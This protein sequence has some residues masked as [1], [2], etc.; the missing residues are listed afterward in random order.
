MIQTVII[1]FSATGNSK[2]VAERIADAIEDSAVSI[3]NADPEI[4]LKPD[5]CLG[6]V[7]PVY[8]GGLPQPMRDYLERLRL[9]GNA[10]YCFS[11][12][13]YGYTS[14]FSA[15]EVKK[16]ISKKG[17]WM[18]AAFGIQMPDTWTPVFDLSDPAAVSKTNKAAEERIKNIIDSI[19][20]RENG[21]HSMGRYPYL[22]RF[23]AKPLYDKA[24][25]TKKFFCEDTCIGCGLCARKCPVH[26]IEII[27][28]KPVWKKDKCALCLRCLHYCPQF[29]I[30]YGN[31]KTKKHG[32]YHNPNVKV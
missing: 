16:L 30:Q 21:I 24:R 32:Q 2:Y 1:Y 14:G 28:N 6:I 17:L 4:T 31:G 5:E 19:K 3:E 22:A 10:G 12:L 25:R 7:F 11:V 29:A 27:D 8:F 18:S 20:N 9:T 26:A 23:I 15:A 13:T